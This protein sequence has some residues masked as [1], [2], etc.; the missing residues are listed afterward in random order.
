MTSG[1]NQKKNPAA[2]DPLQVQW[3]GCGGMKY[4]VMLRT[5]IRIPFTIPAE[6]HCLPTFLFSPGKRC[7]L[8]QS[9]MSSGI[10]MK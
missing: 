8:S 9:R 7:R 3:R 2:Q 6:P 10:I 1:G 4:A 5:E